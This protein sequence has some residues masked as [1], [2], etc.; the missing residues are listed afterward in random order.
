MLTYPGE[1]F[2]YEELRIGYTSVTVLSDS[3]ARFRAIMH[4]ENLLCALE[5]PKEME[6]PATVSK[7]WITDDNQ[8]LL[9]IGPVSAVTQAV[10]SWISGNV[11][12][13]LAGSFFCIDGALLHTVTLEPRSQPQMVPRRL[14]LGGG[15]V[16]IIH[17]AHLNKLIVLYNKTS[18]LRQRVRDVPGKRAMCPSIVFLNPDRTPGIKP[19]PDAEDMENDRLLHAERKHGEKF[20]GITEWFP[21]V[22]G[23]E[24]HMLVVNTILSRGDKPVGRLLFFAITIGDTDFPKLTLKQKIELEAPVYAVAAYP[25]KSLVYC[26]GSVL[27]MQTLAVADLPG[28][29][30]QLP[31]VAAT[32]SAGR[33]LTV[34]EPLIYASSTGESLAVYKY[35][36]DKLVYQYGDQS[37]RDGLHHVHVPEHSLVLASD[38]N[39]AVVGLWQ[40][41]ERRIDNV[42]PSVF[43]AK[44][45]GSITRLRR[46]TRP[47]WH[48]YTGRET[49]EDALI[50]SST[51]GT[52][53][54][55]AI[56]KQGWRLLRFIQ[57]MA[58][59]NPLICPFTK[60]PRKRPIEPSTAK[61]TDMHINGDILQR[62]VDRGGEKLLYGMLS[63][64]PDL[65]SH[66]DFET[67][68]ARWARFKELSKE[69]VNANFRDKVEEAGDVW[70]EEWARQW[71]RMTMSWVRYQLRS[72]L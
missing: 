52:I 50:G 35:E 27:C 28:Y 2:F 48:G 15:P 1:L 47:I 43:E 69:V 21:K 20:L 12:G 3:T 31:I 63:A 54:Q 40:P 36:V 17:S 58:E 59:R 60:P 57:N 44:L 22:G 16:R 51:D 13:F 42:M 61:P 34:R 25:E 38:M 11:P 6:A 55:F 7:I 65:E 56:L 19:N 66:P 67:V 41:P 46:V 49:M 18:V 72:A 68:E 37:A 30:W 45:L 8:P 23:N 53:T 62:V 29:K 14:E 70:N 39:K 9:Q 4:C 10:S 32:R 26:C 71:L 33:C 24:C 5:Y 64:E